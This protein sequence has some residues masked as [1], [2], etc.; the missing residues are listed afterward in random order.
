MLRMW[1]NITKTLKFCKM[2]GFICVHGVPRG[3][4][5]DR[6][7]L[8]Q[9]HEEAHERG[10]LVVISR[11]EGKSLL[12]SKASSAGLIHCCDNADIK[13][14]LKSAM[15]DL[16]TIKLHIMLW[17][18]NASS[19]HPRRTGAAMLRPAARFRQ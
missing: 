13:E 4:A 1:L 7:G 9:L 5:A 18:N 11:L 17:P 15:E 8:R 19:N 10:H 14:T 3:T 2:Q 6:A 16:D 12:P